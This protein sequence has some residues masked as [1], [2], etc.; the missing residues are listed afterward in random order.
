[1]NKNRIIN[2]NDVIFYPSIKLLNDTTISYILNQN[3]TSII[4]QC[5]TSM[6]FVKK[7]NYY[8]IEGD[9]LKLVTKGVKGLCQKQQTSSD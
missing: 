8:Q 4:G 9:V 2:A 5:A 3:H 1:M 7:L 6:E